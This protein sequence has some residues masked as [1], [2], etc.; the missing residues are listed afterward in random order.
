MVRG[1]WHGHRDV[2]L[3]KAFNPDSYKLLTCAGLVKCGSAG[4]GSYVPH[5][6]PSEVGHELSSSTRC[7]NEAMRRVGVLPGVNRSSSRH[8]KRYSAISGR[9]KATVFSLTAA[10][11]E[12][13][14][15]NMV[16]HHVKAN[17]AKTCKLGSSLGSV[18]W[19]A[20]CLGGFEGIPTSKTSVSGGS[21]F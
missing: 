1:A 8:P 2:R 5:L 21:L 12:C 16:L 4:G 11:Q 14:T 17:G 3:R 20:L 15:L 19:R 7:S 9:G 6:R 13:K 10:C 18:I